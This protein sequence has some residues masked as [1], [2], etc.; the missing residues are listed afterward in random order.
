MQLYLIAEIFLIMTKNFIIHQFFEK[1]MF[2]QLMKKI[3]VLIKSNNK[4]I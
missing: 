1:L 2:I 3:K 4:H